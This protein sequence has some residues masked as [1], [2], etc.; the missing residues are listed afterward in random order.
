MVH[1]TKLSLIR[2]LINKCD[3]RTNV[4]KMK[5]IN[6]NKHRNKH[7]NFEV[8]FLIVLLI[9]FIIYLYQT[10]CRRSVYHISGK[11]LLV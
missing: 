8:V 2:L 3:I 5:I 1:G 4:P 7:I 6:K 9:D 11:M 10:H